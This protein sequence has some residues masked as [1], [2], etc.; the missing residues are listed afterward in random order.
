MPAAA[1][2][3]S[4]ALRVL[5][6]CTGNS[7]R[8]QIA[9]ALLSVRGGARVRAESAGSIP[10][11][12]VNPLA[13]RVLAERGIDWSGR[14]P[15]GLEGLAERP[16][17]LV[18]TVCDRAKEACPVFFG[19]PVLAHW[20]MSDPAEVTGPERVRLEA[21]RETLR[22][23]ERRV[24]L[25]LALPPGTREREDFARRVRAIGRES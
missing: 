13:V 1:A 20:G 6:L 23:L 22:V 12:R 17:D 10:A 18:I 14:V 24:D 2:E 4:P 25:L 19:S 11:P 9:E 16:W 7:A 21:F 15:R 3:R 8:S 5:V